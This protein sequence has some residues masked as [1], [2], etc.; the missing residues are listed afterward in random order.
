M[1][2]EQGLNLAGVETVLELEDRLERMR[3]E[4]AAMRART[5]QMER[6]MA[7]EVER[8]RRSFG[9]EIVPYG[10]YESATLAP[11]RTEGAK[12]EA[13]TSR[14]RSSAVAARADAGPGPPAG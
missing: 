11:A 1:T 3:S 5:E 10:A 9:A 14:S 4:L 12:D 6:R 13:G 7:A 2:A 8:A